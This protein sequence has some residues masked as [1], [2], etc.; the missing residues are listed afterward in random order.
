MPAFG[1]LLGATFALLQGLLYAAVGRAVSQRQLTGEARRANAFFVLWWHSLAGLL[2]ATAGFSAAAAFGYINLALHITLLH[3][4]LLVI[5]LA[6]WGLGYYFAYLFT[7]RA[8]WLVPLGVF[9][10]AFFLLLDYLVLLREP[11]AVHL[12]TWST[13]IQYRHELAGGGWTQ[14]LLLL[15]VGPPIVGALAYLSLYF[16]VDAP[17]QKYRIGLVGGSISLWMASGVVASAAG[18]NETGWWRF[19]SSLIGVCAALTILL[20]Y[21]P[22]AAVRRRFE[23]ESRESP[24]VAT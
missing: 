1:P 21:R 20:A 19:V 7:G 12:G 3:A 23:A 4:V 15:L 6:L 11:Y 17:E 22:P 8:H 9:Y 16:R 14:F 5:C 18:W 24:E 13:E 10:G 2:I